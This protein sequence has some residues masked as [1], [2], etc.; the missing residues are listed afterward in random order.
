MGIKQ[1]CNASLYS[2]AGKGK[3][4]S[5]AGIPGSARTRWVLAGLLLLVASGSG[6]ANQTQGVTGKALVMERSKGNCLA[7]HAIADGELPGNI[8][9]ALFAM[10]ERFPEADDLRMQIWDATRRNPD[11]RM[12][13]FGR[14]GILSR[15][16]IDLIV[17]YLYTL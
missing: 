7:C 8:G 4:L 13:P 12:P 2:M 11:S 16:E 15:K 1:V 3:N 6:A 5:V 10:K 17:Q 14:H 9:P